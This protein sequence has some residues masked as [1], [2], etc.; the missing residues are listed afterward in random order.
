MADSM[1]PINEAAERARF[2]AWAV[3]VGIA[4][5]GMNMLGLVHNATLAHFQGCWLAAKQDAAEPR[6]L[7][8]APKDGTS[9][10]AYYP[11]HAI[12]DDG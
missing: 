2:E 5:K 9:F 10:L 7:I 11:A 3:D 8:S 6:P 1:N 4:H 12:R